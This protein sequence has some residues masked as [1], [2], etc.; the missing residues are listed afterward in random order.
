MSCNSV[1]TLKLL[2]GNFLSSHINYIMYFS[3]RMKFYRLVKSFNGSINMRMQRHKK[4]SLRIL[5]NAVNLT[6]QPIINPRTMAVFR[7]EGLP[8]EKG[9]WEQAVLVF[10]LRGTAILLLGASATSC[11]R[12]AASALTR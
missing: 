5:Q 1:S 11:S 9:T 4:S 8:R 12:G 3:D 10:L 2:T 6:D 7:A